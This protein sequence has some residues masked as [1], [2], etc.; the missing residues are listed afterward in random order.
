MECW[1][2]GRPAQG[3]CRFCGRGVCKA[4]AK[5]MPSIVSI[6]PEADGTKKAV[7]VSDALWCNVC[8]PENDPVRA[9]PL[10]NV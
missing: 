9:V 6:W 7:V 8:R 5:K 2:C 1:H 4:H 10:D 3:V